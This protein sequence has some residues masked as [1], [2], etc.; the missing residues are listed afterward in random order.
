MGLCQIHKVLWIIIR[1]GA[2]ESLQFILLQL[3]QCG[4]EVVEHDSVCET[5]ED[6]RQFPEW[7]DAVRE[8]FALNDVRDGEYVGDDEANREDHRHQQD[9][10]AWGNTD[11]FEISEFVSSLDVPEETQNR[12]NP[13]WI[14]E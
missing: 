11:E 3:I 8:S 10:E 2:T 9:A 6:E 14:S 5:L 4:L 12:E 13:P 7:I 1:D